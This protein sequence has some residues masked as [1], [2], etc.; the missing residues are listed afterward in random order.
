MPNIDKTIFIFKLSK[1]KDLQKFVPKCL[2]RG[3]NCGVYNFI[4]S[5]KPFFVKMLLEFNYLTRKKILKQKIIPLFT[6]N[7]L[8]FW[9]DSRSFEVNFTKVNFSLPNADIDLK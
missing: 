2:F 1:S 8:K 7:N 4:T 3:C 5:N 6:K 9:P